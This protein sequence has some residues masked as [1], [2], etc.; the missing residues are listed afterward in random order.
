MTTKL[1]DTDII[2][3]IGGDEFAVILQHIDIKSAYELMHRINHVIS[4]L[5]K[6]PVTT[7]VGIT[8]ITDNSDLIFSYADKALYRS[9]HKGKNCVS[10]H[11]FE[12]LTI[13]DT[14][15]NP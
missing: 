5:S 1:R 14:S 6:V 15:A 12:S 3:R 8:E 7:S 13:I 2:A 10:A 9:K 11:G 4:T